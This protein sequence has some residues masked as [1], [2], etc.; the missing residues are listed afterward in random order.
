MATLDVTAATA[1]RSAVK[2]KGWAIT[3]LATVV[4]TYALDG[5]ATAGGVILVASGVMAGAAQPMLW[6]VLAATYVAWGAGLRVNLKA[7]FELLEA[8]GTSSNALSKA[9]YELV[10]RRART[11]RYPK[12][13]R[14]RRLCRHRDRQGGAVL[15]R[16]I[17]R[18]AHQRHDHLSRCPRL[19]R[20][21]QSRRGSLRVRARQ[22]HVGL[23]AAPRRSP[24][25]RTRSSRRPFSSQP[26]SRA[27][28][29]VSASKGPPAGSLNA[30]LSS[31]TRSE[32]RNDRGSGQ[33]IG[34]ADMRSAGSSW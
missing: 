14:G 5:V 22:G 4:S 28:A 20:R 8:V 34:G 6:L 26:V 16:G 15:R 3:L 31:T 2:V 30:S 7:N 17:W 10:R 29:K 12:G 27:R 32:G 24:E 33:R 13:C 25:T 9:T 11:V 18:R 23:P 21:H 1:I 19:P